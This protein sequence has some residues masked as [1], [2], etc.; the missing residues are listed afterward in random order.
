MI[1]DN[2]SLRE[3]Q[4]A[5][6]EEEF[7]IRETNREAELLAELE[8]EFK[9]NCLLYEKREKQLEVKETLT[10]RDDTYKKC[11]NLIDIL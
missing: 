3:N 7:K 6:K 8:E 10:K 4:Y 2:R 11:S 5:S 1:V 9:Q